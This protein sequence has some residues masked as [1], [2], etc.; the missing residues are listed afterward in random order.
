MRAALPAGL[1]QIAGTQE[2]STTGLS[3]GPVFM[4][5][6]FLSFGFYEPAKHIVVESGLD[7]LTVLNLQGEPLG[8]KHLFRARHQEVRGRVHLGSLRPTECRDNRS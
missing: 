8:S 3:T 2:L 5:P 1:E 6:R 7:D 4:T